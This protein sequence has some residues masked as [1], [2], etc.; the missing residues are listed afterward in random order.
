M[1]SSKSESAAKP[2]TASQVRIYL[3]SEIRR[4]GTLRE[5]AKEW[6]VDHAVLS[7]VA[8]GKREPSP[9]VLDRLGLEKSETTYLPKTPRSG[10][11][12]GPKKN[13][14]D[15]LDLDTTCPII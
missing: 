5:L 7:K 13:P 14:T 12:P 11:D 1:R 9:Q 4:A 15:P 8:S 3:W 2:I 6:G 10:S